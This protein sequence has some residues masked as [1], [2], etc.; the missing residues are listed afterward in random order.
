MEYANVRF[1]NHCNAT[2]DCAF[3]RIVVQRLQNAEQ[4]CTRTFRCR[5][6]SQTARSHAPR[7]HHFRGARVEY[8]NVRHAKR[9]NNGRSIRPHRCAAF[10]Q[11]CIMTRSTRPLAAA[12]ACNPHTRALH[13]HTN[14]LAY[15]WNACATLQYCLGAAWKLLRGCLSAAC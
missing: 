14:F 3:D 2:T 5:N 11:R 8:A 6:G 15:A 4:R 10:A 1:A 7:A 12:M 9:C 13:A